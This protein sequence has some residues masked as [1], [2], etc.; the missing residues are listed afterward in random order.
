MTLA[1][2]SGRRGVALR[3]LEFSNEDIASG[4]KRGR[5]PTSTSDERLHGDTSNFPFGATGL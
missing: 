3:G 5:L 4:L 2:G 1:K